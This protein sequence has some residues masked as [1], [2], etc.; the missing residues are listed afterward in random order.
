MRLRTLL[1][2]HSRPATPPPTN[3]MSQPDSIPRDGLAELKALS[4][5]IN[6]SI[7]KIESNLKTSKLQFP[8]IYT[9]FTFESEAPRAVPEIRD[10][11]ALIA[12]AAAQMIAT[13]RPP[14]ASVCT[15]AMLF[16]MPAALN[17]VSEAHVAEVLHNAGSKGMHISDIARPSGVDPDKL[18][19]I[20]RLLVTNHI[21]I[22][23][24]PDHFAHNRVS[25][26][27]DSGKSV[28]EILK[29]PKN[30]HHGT[31]GIAAAVGHF[32]DEVMRSMSFLSDH[33]LDP[34]SGHSNDISDLPFNRAFD[35]KG[36]LLWKWYDDPSQ[37]HRMARFGFTMDGIKNMAPENAIVE[38]VD[39]K[40]LGES[41]L[42]VDVGGGIGSQCLTL[43]R[44][45][46]NLKFIVQDRDVVLKVATKFWNDEMPGAL[47]SGKVTLQVH[48][49]LEAQPVKDADA[50][51]VRM[52][53]HDY[54][55]DTCLAILRHLRASAKPS[56]QLVIV[57]NIIAYACE[58]PAAQ[59]IPGATLPLPPAPLLAN[60]GEANVVPYLMDVEMMGMTGGWERTFIQFRT[61][62]QKAGW[63][64]VSVHHGFSSQWH[65]TFPYHFPLYAMLFGMRYRGS[66]VFEHCEEFL[67]MGMLPHPAANWYHVSALILRACRLHIGVRI[68]LRRSTR[69]I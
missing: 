7:E 2:R 26:V 53:M 1:Q 45:C 32:A 13:V 33:V 49:F 42:V 56:T 67:G 59:E 68:T 5:I 52:I 38:G 43:A 23:V 66:L 3:T 63:K 6:T 24:S 58:E 25:S 9:P 47:A 31:L 61:L 39:W 28:D 10:A 50:F 44:N 8:S 22:E 64:V 29:D 21:F 30:K 40:G 55:D 41:A 16:S 18:S 11:S 57:D 69:Y 4:S 62:L 17:V 37:Q 27:L 51:L 46:P 20:L 54:P 34:V 35:C 48:N 65:T 15:S 14:P 19:R 36:T 12:S 60:L